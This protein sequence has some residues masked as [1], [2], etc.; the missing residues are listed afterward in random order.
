MPITNTCELHERFGRGRCPICTYEDE[1][2]FRRTKPPEE[3]GPHGDPI[4]WLTWVQR[5]NALVELRAVSTTKKHRAAAVSDTE[6]AIAAAR[7]PW[8]PVRV[9]T[10]AIELDHFFGGQDEALA[11][12]RLSR[13]R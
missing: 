8:P 13:P 5:S 11:L 1:Y 6:G 2:S 9:W 3:I 12:A 7:G 4:V 10:E